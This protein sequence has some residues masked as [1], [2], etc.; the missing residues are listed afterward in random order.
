MRK[1][2]EVQKRRKEDER[3]QKEAEARRIA[4]EKVK[5][6]AEA[7]RIAEE[8]YQE[9]LKAWEQTC[10]SIK[11]Q[12]EQAVADRLSAAKT[13]LEQTA[14]KDYDT[15]VAAATARKKTAQQNKADAELR[16]SKLGMFKFTEK[17]AAKE[18]IAQ[19][20]AE[21]TYAEKD[22]EQAKQAL[23]T[24]LAT[25][26]EKVFAQG[27]AIRNSVEAE[28]PFPAKPTKPS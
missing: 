12:R 11:K 22:L 20:E 3:K 2:A 28:M 10:E 16:L 5:A 13:T 1:E 18:T 7:R 23:R 15:A 9:N 14:Q 25:S 19:A 4:E 27:V 24:T 26:P 21:I 6:E 8:K 17:N